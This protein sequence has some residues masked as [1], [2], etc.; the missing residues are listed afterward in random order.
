VTYRATWRKWIILAH[1]SIGIALSPLFVLW[2]ASGIAMLFTD[3]MPSLS[4]AERLEHL[5]PLDFGR[6]AIAAAVAA[7]GHPYNNVVL[8]SILGRPAYRLGPRAVVFADTGE[9]LETHP[10]PAADL[11]A[12]F[13]KLPSS[14]GIGPAQLIAVRDQWTFG[15]R[16]VLPLQKFRVDDPAATEIYVSE[17]RGEVVLVTT[18]GTRL[19]A[20][21]SAIPHWFYFTALRERDALWR[22]VVLWTSGVGSVSAVLGL[23]LAVLQF[24]PRHPFQVRRITTYNP[25]AGW[26][27]WH[28]V[29]GAFFGV[30]ALT[31]AS[32]GLL[33][34]QPGDWARDRLDSVGIQAA[35][36]GGRLDLSRFPIPALG[37]LAKGPTGAIKE[38]EFL[39]IAGEPYFGLSENDG[40]TAI[41]SVR[42]LETR[43]DA[44]TVDAVARAVAI[45]APGVPVLETAQLENH[46]AYYYAGR[47]SQAPLPVVRVKLGDADQ[48]WLYVDPV[49]G[50]IRA[51]YGRLARRERWLYHGLHSLDFAFWYG[52]RPLWT[53]GMICLLT[54][55]LTVSGTSA[56]LAFRRVRRFL[57]RRWG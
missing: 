33:S 18:R 28:Y 24:S 35:L 53:V 32:S 47:D 43:T 14:S 21:L 6:V 38:I 5:P 17:A 48:T 49:R 36:R 10:A 54:G 19:A 16:H 26:M 52:N 20:W 11:A 46:D 7:G 39:Q 51:A 12:V 15:L 22:Q 37:P 23:V 57:R 40:S 30:F 2:F 27:R 50:E 25:Y 44:L 55:G 3:G 9:L 13:L 45:G 1:R 42:S 34:M 29:S 4:R 31:W 56:V 41:V 8:T